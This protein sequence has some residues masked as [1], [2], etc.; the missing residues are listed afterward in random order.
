MAALSESAVRLSPA[1]SPLGGI[2]PVPDVIGMDVGGVL[3]GPRPDLV[4][5]TL[6]SFCT[7]HGATAPLDSD[8][9]A[10]AIFR[11]AAR[12]A[13]SP[14]PDAYWRDHRNW[15]MEWA[16]LAGIPVELA[17]GA[18]EALEL[19]DRPG[20][21]LW[22][23]LLPDAVDVLEEFHRRKIAVVAVSNSSGYLR[24]ELEGAGLMK[25]F[26]A[27]IDSEVVG[28]RKPDRRIFQAA[29][30]AVRKHDLRSW[31]FIGDDPHYDV[32]AALAAGCGVGLLVD[33][34]QQYS[35]LSCARIRRLREVVALLDLAMGVE[36][37]G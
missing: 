17:T 28:V 25:Y 36:D 10:D 15:Q 4:L 18:W 29:A 32:A 24:S 16:E 19:S 26:D 13:T 20:A 14:D 21:P 8:R 5:H 22:T 23:A 30:T 3:L 2:L 11:V 34:L 1:S 37:A 9:C 12:A 27:V 33:R 6:S 7:G 31:W 35:H